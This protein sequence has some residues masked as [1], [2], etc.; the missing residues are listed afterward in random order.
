MGWVDENG[1]KAHTKASNSSS[2]KKRGTCESAKL[3][4]T[5][6]TQNVISNCGFDGD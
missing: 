3:T 5:S 1:P 4:M 6:N 2:A